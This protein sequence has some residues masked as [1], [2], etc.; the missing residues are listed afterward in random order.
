MMEGIYT[1]KDR[2]LK[3][4]VAKLRDTVREAKLVA[5]FKDPSLP[6]AHTHGWTMFP[7]SQFKITRR[8]D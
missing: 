5:Q 7:A 8:D 3:G 4:Q 1:G 2:V 6:Q